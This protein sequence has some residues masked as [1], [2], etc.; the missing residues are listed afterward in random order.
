[1]TDGTLLSGVVINRHLGNVSGRVVGIEFEGGRK[2]GDL[3][4]IVSINHNRPG[5]HKGSKF[6]IGSLDKASDKAGQEMFSGS[7]TGDYEHT[8]TTEVRS[9]KLSHLIELEGASDA[10]QGSSEFSSEVDDLEFVFK[11]SG[12]RKNVDVSGS[13]WGDA[14]K[15]W[16]DK[17]GNIY[18]K[19]SNIVTVVDVDVPLKSF[20]KG[21]LSTNH[22]KSKHSQKSH[23]RG[24]SSS[25]KSNRAKMAEMLRGHLPSK[26]SQKLAKADRIARQLKVEKDALGSK[27]NESKI[28]SLRTKIESKR[29]QLRRVEDKLVDIID[30]YPDDVDMGKIV[31]TKKYKT[32]NTKRGS[33][34]LDVKKLENDLTKAGGS[35]SSGI[36]RKAVQKPQGLPDSKKV[37]GSK[38]TVGDLKKA[39]V[40]AG[41]KTFGKDLENDGVHMVV[42]TT[43]AKLAKTDAGAHVGDFEYPFFPSNPKRKAR[44][45]SG[46]KI[47]KGFA[48]KDGKVYLYDA[49]QSAVTIVTVNEYVEVVL[50]HLKSKHNQKTHGGGGGSGD[51]ETKSLSSFDDVLPTNQYGAKSGVV[52]VGAVTVSAN[53]VG[54]LEAGNRGGVFF[55]DNVSSYQSFHEGHSVQSYKIS[56]KNAVVA[57]HQNDLT[58]AWFN[59]GYGEMIDGFNRKYGSQGAHVANAKFDKKM[60]SMAK[61]KGYDGVIFLAPAPPASREVAVIGKNMKSVT[62]NEHGLTLH[63]LKSKHSQKSHGGG[64]GTAPEGGSVK[65]KIAK[66]SA[67]RVG[68]KIQRYAE[69]VNEPILAKGLGGKSADDNEPMD[70]ITTINGRNHG[71]ELKTMTVG[72]NAKITMKASAI[73]R[74]KSWERKNKATGHT[75]VFDDTKVFNAKGPGKHDVSKRRILYR[76]GYG[77]F[78]TKNM[79]EVSSMKDLKDIMSKRKN[80]IPVSAGG[81]KRS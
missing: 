33:L 78:R 75:V 64:G 26:H 17:D 38:Y 76:R 67:V 49:E 46:R 28:K 59:K 19:W 43:T 20:T 72:G 62:I 39:S 40:S 34:R 45:V 51:G 18:T 58:Q 53:R 9:V 70:V 35:L 50:N 25:T 15:N 60:L 8:K 56:L 27:S 79:L 57:G 23:G 4:P 3:A 42:K 44:N 61:K 16:Q 74:K 37:A 24:G 36:R 63:H 21:N 65:S 31:S 47:I 5:D 11:P 6:T 41:T 30:S 69:N 73:K 68:I 12:G 10:V 81:S 32:A 66:K 55:G 80:Q 54:P 7:N 2:V 77:S 48:D 14:A 52:G 22:L 1:M 71:V 13:G 29:N